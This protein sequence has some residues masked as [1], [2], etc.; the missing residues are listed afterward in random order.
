MKKIFI[1]S[2]LIIFSISVFAQASTNN[3]LKSLIG[4]SFN[5]YPRVKEA[6]NQIEIA[7]ESLDLAKTNLPVID[8]NGTYEYVQPK[9]TLP[10]EINGH[11]QSFQFAPVNNVNGN[12]EA[13]F[14]L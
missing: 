5:Y 11:T 3:E 1:T 14:V 12:V 2:A 7:Q 13:S 8:A 6:T 4:T 9:I 10:L